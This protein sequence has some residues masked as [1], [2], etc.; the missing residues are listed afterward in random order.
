[1]I[2]VVIPVYD[3]AESIEELHRQLA[4]FASSLEDTLE[5]IFV[6]DGSRDGSWPLISR[7]AVRDSRVLGI[8]L[9]RNFGKAAALAA[10]FNAAR[11]EQIVTLDGDLQDDPAEVPKLLAQLGQDCDVACGWKQPRYDPWHKV[12]PSWIFNRL[13]GW[14]TGVW[15]HDHNCGLKAFQRDVVHEIRLYGELH[16]FIPVL[17]ASRGFRVAEVVI[18]HRPR[19]HGKSKYGVGR[20]TKGF[21]DLLSVKF[22]TG[23]GDR[24]QHFLGTVG[25]LSFVLGG[26]GLLSLAV[27]WC[28]SRLIDGLQ[29]VHLHQTAAL[30]YS[31]ALCIV[32]AQFLSVGLLGELIAAF[33]ARDM[34]T[35][36]IA[37]HTEPAADSKAD[38]AGSRAKTQ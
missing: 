8:R 5:I 36:S 31:L 3:E 35:Y 11:G 24:P 19:K 23:Y 20:F 9:R 17:A 27:R 22:I 12:I 32:G 21:L 13:V 37:E 16:R 26:L 33:L 2:S 28:G 30:Y 15:L 7:L 25:L 29:P 6:D 38:H 14:L 10:G 18:N 34:D 4:E 1:M